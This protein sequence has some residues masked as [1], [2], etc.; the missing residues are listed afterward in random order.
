LVPMGDD[1]AMAEALGRVV[2]DAVWR[3]DLRERALERAEELSSERA[4]KAWE[5][6]LSDV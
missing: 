4:L 5:S 6:L 2:G 1:A 3:Q